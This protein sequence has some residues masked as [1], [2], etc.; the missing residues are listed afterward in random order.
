MAKQKTMYGSVT[1]K[2]VMVAQDS[3]NKQ[4]MTAQLIGNWSNWGCDG[5]YLIDEDGNRYSPLD[6]KQCFF[7]RQLYKELT[8]TQFVIRTMKEHLAR[9]I[10][11]DNN[12]LAIPF[13]V[14]EL[15]KS[16]YFRITSK[17]V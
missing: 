7:G 3:K 15:I 17:T 14:S 4:L 8:G 10:K 13:D 1:R 2:N 16:L 9:K 12:P 5:N 6:V 11:T